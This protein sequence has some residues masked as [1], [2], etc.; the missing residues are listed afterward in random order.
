MGGQAAGFNTDYGLSIVALSP[1]RG[2]SL[3]LWLSQLYAF[4][5]EQEEQQTA[6]LH[7]VPLVRATYFTARE[8]TISDPYSYRVTVLVYKP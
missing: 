8:Q 6:F 3:N 4:V 1:K 7:I 5:L 2:L